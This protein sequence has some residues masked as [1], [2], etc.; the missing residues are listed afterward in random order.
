VT[1]NKYTKVTLTELKTG[2]HDPTVI[3]VETYLAQGD[4]DDKNLDN[5]KFKVTRFFKWRANL[6]LRFLQADE[7]VKWIE[8]TKPKF[9]A[10]ELTNILEDTLKQ[11]EE[12]RKFR[13]TEK[14][15]KEKE[16][17]VIIA[18][19]EAINYSNEQRKRAPFVPEK[20]SA[21]ATFE[22]KWDDL[23][24]VVLD[25]EDDLKDEIRRLLALENLVQH[26][27]HEAEEIIEWIKEKDTFLSDKSHQSIE[28]RGAAKSEVAKL[29]MFNLEYEVR[30]FFLLLLLSFNM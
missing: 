7:L 12:L 5:L 27:K 25:Y 14:P 6:T 10:L 24:E 23:T 30:Y 1:N 3:Y 29:S 17:K 16:R 13:T 26:F 19:R 9:V 8:A 11:Y 28:K 4:E 18:T 2:H 22:E 15:P 21:E 20:G